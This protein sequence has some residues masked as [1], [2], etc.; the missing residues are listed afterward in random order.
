MQKEDIEYILERACLSKAN[1]NEEAANQ[2]I[3]KALQKKQKLL[4]YYR[5]QFC[6]SIHLTSQVPDNSRQKLEVI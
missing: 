1:L 6:N 2:I 4:Y 3:D 5:C